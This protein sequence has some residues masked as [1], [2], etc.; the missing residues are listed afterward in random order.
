MSALSLCETCGTPRA[1]QSRCCPTC[2][3]R[4]RTAGTANLAALGL[5]ALVGCGDKEDLLI[6]PAYGIPA[7][8]G[9]Y[10]DADG[11]G[12]SEADGDCDDEDETVNPGAEEIPGDGID[13]NCDGQDDT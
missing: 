10:D 8:S 7:D 2:C 4:K 3:A 1:A 13:S 6:E 12:Y 11:D 9:W 5:V